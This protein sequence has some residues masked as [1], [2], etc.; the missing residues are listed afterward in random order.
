MS[1]AVYRRL[2][3]KALVHILK[4][5]V[6]LKTHLRKAREKRWMGKSQAEKKAAASHASR[7]YWDA[8]TPAERSAEMKRRVKVRA[9]NRAQKK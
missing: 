7:A 5:M 3:I 8:L 2:Q 6:D 1:I 4:A 9:K